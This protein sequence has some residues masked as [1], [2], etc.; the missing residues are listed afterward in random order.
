MRKTIGVALF[1]IF[2]IT[3]LATPPSVDELK[4]LFN[5]DAESSMEPHAAPSLVNQEN[6]NRIIGFCTGKEYNRLMDQ[7]NRQFQR[8]ENYAAFATAQSA[9]RVSATC[10]TLSIRKGMKTN[11]VKYSFEVGSA[12]VFSNAARA[13]KNDRDTKRAIRYLEYAEANGIKVATTMLN[14]IRKK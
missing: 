6:E 10:A 9:A 5:I 8:G 13:S 11:Y 4:D 7:F 14:D 12:L 1:L 3:A 2:P